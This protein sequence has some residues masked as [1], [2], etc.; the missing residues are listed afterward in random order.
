M[1]RR[2]RMRLELDG[3]AAIDAILR[4]AQERAALMAVAC[5][6]VE[7]GPARVVFDV[8]GPEAMVGAFEMA[9]RLGPAGCLVPVVR[10]LPVPGP[11]SGD[12]GA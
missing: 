12:D 6:V 10:C 9:C 3:C 7:S 4:F 8:A 1:S 2:E 5:V 11:V